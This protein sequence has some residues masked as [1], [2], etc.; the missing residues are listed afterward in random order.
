MQNLCAFY[1]FFILQRCF[2]FCFISRVLE[3]VTPRKLYYFT[4][5]FSTAV[6]SVIVNKSSSPPTAEKK[7]PVFVSSN[8]VDS[9]ANCY[10]YP[11]R[12]TVKFYV[13]GVLQN[14]NKSLRCKNQLIFTSFDISAK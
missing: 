5:N 13:T 14:N 6:H 2:R 12:I 7:S 3:K 11:L 10:I 9:K 8:F 1:A 4:K